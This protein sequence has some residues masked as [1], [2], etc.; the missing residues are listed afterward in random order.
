MTEESIPGIVG[1]TIRVIVVHGELRERISEVS[2]RRSMG[3]GNRPP[4]IKSGTGSDLLDQS[5]PVFPVLLSPLLRLKDTG[6]GF[7]QVQ[8]APFSPGD[9]TVKSDTPLF[10]EP[11]EY[12]K[13]YKEWHKSNDHIVCKFPKKFI[14]EQAVFTGRIQSSLNKDRGEEVGFKT[15]NIEEMYPKKD[16]Q[17]LPIGFPSFPDK[18]K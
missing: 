12:I 4:L 9:V 18:W 16:E 1:V 14:G 2:G 7:I 13:P 10:P 11:D 15:K 5:G 8:L 3:L 6:Y 17:G